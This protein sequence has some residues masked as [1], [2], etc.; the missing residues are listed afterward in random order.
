M[1][2]KTIFII[3][4]L[5]LLFQAAPLIL[6]LFSVDIKT[7]LLA[8]TFGSEVSNDAEIGRASCRERV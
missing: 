2:I 4:S 6:S 3:V 1:R 5:L 7:M 8:D